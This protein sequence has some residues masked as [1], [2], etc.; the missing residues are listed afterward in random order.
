MWWLIG[1][2]VLLIAAISYVICTALLMPD[3]YD[4]DLSFLDGIDRD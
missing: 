3:D 2:I 4:V 1:I